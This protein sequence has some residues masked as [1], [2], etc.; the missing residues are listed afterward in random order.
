MLISIT[1][2]NESN[3]PSEYFIVATQF[4]SIT[5]QFLLPLKT[6]KIK[7]IFLVEIVCFE[8]NLY[9]TNWQFY[10][11]PILIIFN[12]GILFIS[13]SIKSIFFAAD[14]EELERNEHLNRFV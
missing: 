7:R 14:F 4:K 12:K 5:F 11:P 2:F 10:E 6:R 1:C 8:I 13:V 9:F 3:T